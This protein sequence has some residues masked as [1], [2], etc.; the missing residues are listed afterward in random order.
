MSKPDP[1]GNLDKA[2]STRTQLLKVAG[3]TLSLL[4]NKGKEIGEA[5]QPVQA[6]VVGIGA[7]V[8]LCTATL[9]E[10]SAL[11]LGGSAAV[12]AGTL[13]YVAKTLE[14]RKKQQEVIQKQVEKEKTHKRLNK[15][16]S[17]R[18]SMLGRSPE[19][20]SVLIPN[21]KENLKTESMYFKETLTK[22]PLELEA[23]SD[24][25]Y[26]NSPE[27]FQI[28]GQPQEP[29]ALPQSSKQEEDYETITEP[30]EEENN[31]TD[32]Q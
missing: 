9:E 13:A 32:T 31:T 10:P 11:Q 18:I 23:W 16:I 4:I 8:L 27:Q 26:S 14:D 15:G 2:I 12:G 19:L 3:E 5:S 24:D 29:T 17:E 21:L 6:A 7:G 1:K 20:D 28:E 22:D 30:A 25:S